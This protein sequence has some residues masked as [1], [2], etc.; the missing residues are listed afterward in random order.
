[1]T[2]ET[3]PETVNMIQGLSKKTLLLFVGLIV[4]AHSTANA[5]INTTCFD[6]KEAYQLSSC[7]NSTATRAATFDNLGSTLS[8]TCGD[9]SSSYK[10]SSCCSAELSNVATM[11]IQ[12][13]YST[14]LNT[15]IGLCSSAPGGTSDN[16]GC[17]SDAECQE[18]C[19]ADSSCLG[20][21]DMS[22]KGWGYMTKNYVSGCFENK[23][24]FVLRVKPVA[25][26]TE[27][28]SGTSE[29]TSGTSEPTT[30]EPTTS[31]PSGEML[32]NGL[33]LRPASS[34]EC[35]SNL[36]IGNCESGGLSGGDLCEA[37]GEC[38]TNTQLDN[39]G[40]YDI[41]VVE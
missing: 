26:T 3:H 18:M 17:G 38:G 11:T 29:P 12:E 34:S 28:T 41:Y 10:G 16:G 39:C 7:C 40:G 15:N 2:G 14:T 36:D 23:V 1:L 35:P 9:L 27:P 31:E 22:A 8:L 6:L 30:S 33:S 32:C 4:A 25:A 21:I 5:P 24:G 13:P 19:N 20:Y 37:D